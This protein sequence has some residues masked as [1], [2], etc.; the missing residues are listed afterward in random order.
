M[1]II[2]A[3]AGIIGRQI[4]QNLCNNHHDVV[5]IDINKDKCEQLYTET[6]ALTIH[7]DATDIRILEKAGCEKADKL[8][9]VMRQDSDNIAC[10]LLAKSLGAKDIIS[11][12]RVPEYRN[13]FKLA[14]INHIISVSGVLLNQFMMEIEEPTVRRIVHIG[15]RKAA[16]F[17]VVVPDNAQCI[18]KSIQ[19]ITAEKSFPD[20]SVIAGIYRTREDLFVAPRGD[21]YPEA[22]DSVFYVTTSAHIAQVSKAF[23]KQKK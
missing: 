14:G 6:G 21:T 7:G 4:T 9:A 18:G 3:G 16:L 1:Y 22:G 19:Q 2:I 8:V 20:E 10:A 12:L 15:K 23:T 11:R 5:V 17:S 13:A